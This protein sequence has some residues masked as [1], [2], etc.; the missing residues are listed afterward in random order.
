M[1]SA[2][3]AIGFKGERR[4]I[5]GPDMLDAAMAE[6]AGKNNGA[7]LS[8][9]DFRIHKM[10]ATNLILHWCQKE[11]GKFEISNAVATLDFLSEGKPYVAALN[12]G[13]TASNQRQ[14]Y[15]EA[16]ILNQCVFNPEAR[17]AKL[18]EM[19]MGFSTIKILVSMNKG[20]H[21]NALTK[22]ESTQWIFCRWEGAQW[23]LPNNLSGATLTIDQTLGS[24]LTRARA[25]LNK[26]V[27]GY[28]YFSAGK[29][30]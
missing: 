1:M 6:I 16:T 25:E 14:P 24:R 7:I 17:I 12:E 5:Y 15:D 29:T 27:I 13:S 4:Y 26:N 3:L 9:V 30:I 11:K 28:V 21:L 19:P 23:P 22:P 20:L 10:T 2:E 8:Q 18:I